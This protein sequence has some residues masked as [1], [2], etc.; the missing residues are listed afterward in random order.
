MSDQM[1]M[2]TFSHEHTVTVDTVK[3]NI[4]VRKDSVLLIK[5]VYLSG[6]A[7][8]KLN[9]L[10]MYMKDGET[11][12]FGWA[13]Y[14]VD[15]GTLETESTSDQTVKICIIG[16]LVGPDFVYA[17]SLVLD[18]SEPTVVKQVRTVTKMQSPYA[19]RFNFDE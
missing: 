3:S 18:I 13:P 4:K 17:P 19:R 8:L 9:G 6:N 2:Y 14:R 7:V 5:S 10:E 12:D 15:S 11:Y 16:T 1:V